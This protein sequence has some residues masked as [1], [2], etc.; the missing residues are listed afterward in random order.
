M[1]YE[2]WWKHASAFQKWPFS[3]GRNI[4]YKLEIFMNFV[5][6]AMVSLQ[7]II[8]NLAVTHCEESTQQNLTCMRKHKI[9]IYIIFWQMHLYIYM[10]DKRLSGKLCFHLAYILYSWVSKIGS[11]FWDKQVVPEACFVHTHSFCPGFWSDTEKSK[12]GV[13]KS[14]H[15]GPDEYAFLMEALCSARICSEDVK[16][17]IPTN[18]D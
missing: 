2:R 16:Y 11:Y 15:E 14:L 5:Y 12:K 3:V 17:D 1:A 9:H 13:C 8:L 10:Q 18:T 7:T 6:K 4:L